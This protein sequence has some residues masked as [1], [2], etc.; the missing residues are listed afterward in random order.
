M[1]ND[2][3][4]LRSR[5]ATLVGPGPDPVT[6]DEVMNRVKDGSTVS[7]PTWAPRVIRPRRRSALLW[8][9]G[10][11]VLIVAL[12]LGLGP[13]ESNGGSNSP[14]GHGAGWHQITFGGLRLSVPTSWPV[15]SENASDCGTTRVPYFVPSSVVLVTAVKGTAEACLP[16]GRVGPMYGLV[17]DTDP[18]APLGD[19]NDNVCQEVNDRE[20]CPDTGTNFGQCEDV[21]G[22]KACPV[23][24]YG[25]VQDFV[26]NIPG[27]SSPVAVEIGLAGSGQI[28]RTILHSMRESGSTPDVP[29]TTPT[30]A[31]TA[32]TNK[33]STVQWPEH[34]IATLTGEAQDIVPTSD[35]IYWLSVNGSVGPPQSIAPIRY[36]PTTEQLTKGPNISGFVGSPAL[37]VTGGWVWVAVAVGKSVV[38]EQFYP[39]TLSLH[40][41]WSYSVKDNISTASMYPSLAATVDGPLW[42]AS[43]EDL[44]AL[45]PATGTVEK[46]FDSHNEISSMST[47][48]TGSLLYTGGGT[49]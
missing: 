6:A 22:L 38:V 4:E 42:V 24:N 9:G 44:W 30:T 40:M 21:N 28:A 25:G 26:V 14:T 36:N 12:V 46:Q 43:G 19:F 49:P 13:L 35:G 23:T 27:R 7:R 39:S 34:I 32:T 15:R 33:T 16:V 5:I 45:N 41:H 17:I 48:P 31:T 20:V 10:V 3:S 2:D 1:H 47:D 18:D 11:V 29:P 8:V 37:T